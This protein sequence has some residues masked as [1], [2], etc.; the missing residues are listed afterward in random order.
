MELGVLFAL[1]ELRINGL[2]HLD[3]LVDASVEVLKGSLVV[4]HRHAFGARES[5]DGVLGSVADGLNLE[6]QRLH[7]WVET[8]LDEVGEGDV[9]LFGI[10][11]SLFEE[12]GEGF[13]ALEV[14]GD[15]IGVE[16]GGHF[17]SVEVEEVVIVFIETRIF[18]VIVLLLNH[19][20][21]LIIYTYSN[22]HHD[23]HHSP[24]INTSRMFS[25][26]LNY[27]AIEFPVKPRIT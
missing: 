19:G 26:H 2:D 8:G 3:G 12:E 10:V 22:A 9:V 14:G 23:Q 25:T 16:R 11:F 27:K 15:G 1:K 17:A 13:Q 20:H 7:V 21:V 5:G 24:A 4:F 18:V 6:A